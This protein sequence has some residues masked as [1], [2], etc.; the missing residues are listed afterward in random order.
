M[1]NVI[2]T[3]A[4]MKII[5]KLIQSYTMANVTQAMLRL[6]AKRM[7]G[8]PCMEDRVYILAQITNENSVTLQVT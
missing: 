2:V 5:A 6:M 4:P 7:Y 1:T 8:L 3:I